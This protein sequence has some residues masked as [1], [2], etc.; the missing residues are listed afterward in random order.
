MITNTEP[1]ERQR[2]YNGAK[3]KT[4]L[5]WETIGWGWGWGVEG[6]KSSRD[7]RGGCEHV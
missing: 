3:I 2:Q 1:K 6:E 4:G 7:K 5:K